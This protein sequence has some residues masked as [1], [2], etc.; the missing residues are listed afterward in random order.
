VWLCGEF[1]HPDLMHGEEAFCL[2][3]LS[4]AVEF[5]RRFV[6]CMYV[7]M[8]MYVNELINKGVCL[9]GLMVCFLV[10]FNYLLA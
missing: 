3:Q 1:R 8:Y 6:F 7:C 9:A 10:A 2:S 4:S 5:A